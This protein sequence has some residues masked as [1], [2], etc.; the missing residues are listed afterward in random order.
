MNEKWRPYLW[1]AMVWQRLQITLFLHSF[2]IKRSLH[3]LEGT[4]Q[5][6]RNLCFDER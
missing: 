4:L 6:L 5:L 1:Q 2:R 3:A